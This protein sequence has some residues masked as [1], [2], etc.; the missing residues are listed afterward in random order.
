M[1]L[2][3]DTASVMLLRWIGGLAFAIGFAVLL[4]LIGDSARV[5]WTGRHHR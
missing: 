1:G 5:W 3:L 2:D 4:T